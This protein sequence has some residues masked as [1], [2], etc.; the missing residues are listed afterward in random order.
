M[1]PLPFQRL[2][3]SSF[4]AADVGPGAGGENDVEIVIR[5]EDFLSQKPARHGFLDCFLDDTIAEGE[6]ASNINER[7]MTVDGVSSDDDP[8]D[9]LVRIAFD[10]DAA[11]A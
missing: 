7:Q 9:K 5:A 11:V 6:F 10:E 3:E 2:D 8:R 1:A 4:L